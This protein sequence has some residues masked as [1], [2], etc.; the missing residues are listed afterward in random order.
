M[1]LIDVMVSVRHGESADINRERKGTA[2][3]P[4]GS[5]SIPI[6]A[7]KCE[8]KQVYATGGHF[9]TYPARGALKGTCGPGCYSGTKTI[10]PT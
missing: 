6:L 3:C 7:C 5:L 1:T 10:Y 4:R 8:V 2:G 9:W